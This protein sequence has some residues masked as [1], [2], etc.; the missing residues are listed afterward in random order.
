[1]IALIALANVQKTEVG[2]GERVW[3]WL[4]IYRTDV[5]YSDGKRSGLGT[6]LAVAGIECQCRVNRGFDVNHRAA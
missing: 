4:A 2:S 6:G 1:M 5:Y 3:W